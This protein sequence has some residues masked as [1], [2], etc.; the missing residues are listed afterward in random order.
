VDSRYQHPEPASTRDTGTAQRVAN[1]RR[2][3][4]ESE[5]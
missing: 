1:H 3:G 4:R 5:H 2:T